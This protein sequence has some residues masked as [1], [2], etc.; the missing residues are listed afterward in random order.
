MRADPTKKRVGISG[1]YGRLNLGDEAILTAII[2]QLRSTLPVEITVF[3][4]DAKNTLEHHAVDHAFQIRDMSRHEA[5]QVLQNLD[6]L[7]LGGGS[8][9]F[10][11]E[12]EI[13]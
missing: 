5:I 12:A 13:Y 7:I 9:F 10:D 3:S 4:R 11:A 6:L 1:S 8:I 2:A